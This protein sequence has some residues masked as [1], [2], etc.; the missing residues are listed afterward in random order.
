[1]SE[2]KKT[3]RYS[4]FQ[5]DTRTKSW[6]AVETGEF[7]STARTPRGVGRAAAASPKIVNRHLDIVLFAG[8]YIW[9]GGCV[10]GVWCYELEDGFGVDY[11]REDGIPPE[12]SEKRDEYKRYV[13]SVANARLGE[14]RRGTIATD[15]T[16]YEYVVDKALSDPNCRTIWYIKDG[17]PKMYVVRGMF[18]PQNVDTEEKILRFI[19]ESEASNG[20]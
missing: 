14:V 4:R 11:D 12:L 20:N 1:M 2:N 5:Y 19:Q 13:E 16:V 9:T 15:G 18:S 7:T 10:C 8:E 3:F 17:Q 6:K